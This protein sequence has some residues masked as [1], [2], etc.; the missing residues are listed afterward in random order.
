MAVLMLSLLEDRCG[1][2]SLVI[3]AFALLLLIASCSIFSLG[4]K[5]VY[6]F[7]HEAHVV[8]EEMDCEMCHNMD[9]ESGVPSMPGPGLCLLCH[10][11]SDAEKPQ[12]RRIHVLFENDVFKAAHASSLTDEVIFDHVAHVERNDDCASC[13]YGIEESTQITAADAISMEQCISCHIQH[14]PEES[15][16]VCHSEVDQQWQPGSHSHLW[17]KGH[18]MVARSGTTL[19]AQRCELCHSESTCIQ[20]HE[21]EKPDNHDNYWRLR[22][23]GVVASMDRQNC[24]TCHRDDY[25]ASCHDEARPL[26]H[27]GSFGSP[28]NTH[29]VSCHFPL[30]GEGCVTCHRSTPS[31]D[32]ATP[33]PPDHN[34]AMNCR[35]CHGAGVPLRHID[36]GSDCILCHR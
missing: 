3:G 2:K 31:H 8:G 13:H 26:S 21:S 15:C 20:C 1:R 33:L 4:G 27:T 5:D 19:Q 12:E 25:C 17:K 14:N 28:R 24:Q 7:T 30:R 36:D 11:D 10:K 16:S 18:G 34:I 32:A 22:G 23:H 35:L 9:T 6:A 29:C